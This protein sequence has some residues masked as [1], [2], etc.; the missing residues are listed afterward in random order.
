MWARRNPTDNG[1]SQPGMSGYGAFSL[2]YS[3]PH[4]KARLTRPT[5]LK[6]NLYGGLNYGRIGISA[7][8]NAW[9]IAFLED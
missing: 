9:E 2:G 7:R 1:V 5:K 6:H 8:G 4:R 3:R